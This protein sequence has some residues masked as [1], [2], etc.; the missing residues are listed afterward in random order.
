MTSSVTVMTKSDLT[1]HSPPVERPAFQES[2]LE[3]KGATLCIG[4]L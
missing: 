2:S 4:R 1:R 3:G